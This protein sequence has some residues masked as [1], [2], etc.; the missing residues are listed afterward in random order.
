MI[1]RGTLAIAIGIPPARARFEVVD[2]LPTDLPLDQVSTEVFALINEGF[3][4]RPDLA[5]VRAE[6]L[7]AEAHI[8]SVRAE[9]FPTIGFSG[10][11]QTLFY[12]DPNTHANNY[13]AS[14]YVSFPLFDGFSKK[15]DTV[16]ARAEAEAT[17]A[18]VTS[19]QQQVGLQI[20][21]N[22]FQ[23]TTTAERIK[24]T[25]RI[26]ESAQQAYEVA[27]GRYKEGVGNILDVLAA[28][29]ALEDARAQDVRTRTEWFLALGA[30]NRN[31]GTLGL[32]DESSMIFKKSDGSQD[33]KQ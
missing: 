7:K 11:A 18:R 30:L 24:T 3:A 6:A 33:V 31:M 23:L 2:E 22:Y 5:A 4:R 28:Q 10:S 17:K 32:P 16:Q 25:R 27:S 9:Q 21:T 20:W 1:L 8:R 19:F 13:S 15:Y 29:S 14:L 26:M 12:L